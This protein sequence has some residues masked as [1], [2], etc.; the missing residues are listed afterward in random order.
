MSTKA[1][2]FD[3]DGTLIDTEKH[4]RVFWPKA[5]AEF[6]YT[7]T[8][9]QVF[10]MRSLGRPFAPKQ[11]KEWFGEDFDYYAVRD[12]RKV[13]M[14]ELIDREGIQLK[15]GAIEILE[16]LKKRNI[17]AA[18]DTA[19]DLE[20]TEK[21]LKMTGIRQYFDRLISATQVKEGKPSP[22]IY[23]FACEQLGLSPEE[24]IAVED[25]PNGVT[26][27]YR[28]GCKV[29]MV[30]DQTPADDAVKKMLFAYVP[31]LDKI[32]EYLDL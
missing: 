16:E 13:L 17:L 9:E 6:G 32:T 5:M 29:I 11:L 10:F 22:D 3:M 28:A 4:Y 31:S 21:Y 7:L 23:Q 24:C 30:P 18:I 25:S 1:V 12:R 20:R 27:A 19:T 2:L 26:S 8:D 14:E 15:P